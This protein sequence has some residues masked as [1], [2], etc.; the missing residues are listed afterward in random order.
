VLQLAAH[1]GPAV[2]FGSLTQVIP[3]A[4][5]CPAQAWAEAQQ[6]PLVKTSPSWQQVKSVVFGAAQQ[7]SFEQQYPLM[8]VTPSL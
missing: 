8:Q 1:C 3:E 6:Y 4:Q 7:L 5:H 2:L